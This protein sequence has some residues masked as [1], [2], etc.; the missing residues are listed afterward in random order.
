MIDI[1][2]TDN[3]SL[4]RNYDDQLAQPLITSNDNDNDNDNDKLNIDYKNSKNYL[5]FGHQ[6]RFQNYVI[7]SI[8]SLLP[9]K[10]KIKECSVLN[11]S[12]LCLDVLPITNSNQVKFQLSLVYNGDMGS[13]KAGKV[14]CENM[15][16]T[17]YSVPQEKFNDTFKISRN[18][19]TR[20]L[21]LFFVR[22]GFSEHNDKKTGKKNTSL[23]ESG[24][25]AS[26]YSGI[27]F[28]KMYPSIKIEAV[29][30]SDLIRTQE[31][32]GHFLS[33]LTDFNVNTPIIVLPCLHESVFA[34]GL[35]QSL[36]FLYD[37]DN[38]DKGYGF[39][40]LTDCNIKEDHIEGDTNKTNIPFQGD[41]YRCYY[42]TINNNNIPID[43][44]IYLNFYN[45]KMREPE[46]WYNSDREHCRNNHFLGMFFNYLNSG[47]M[48]M[49]I[50]KNRIKGDFYGGKK[51]RQ[52]KKQRVMKS[53]KVRRVKKHN[54][55]SKKVKRRSNKRKA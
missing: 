45:G 27:E 34:D 47:G 28:N 24:V 14:Y 23:L 6:Y 31:T 46:S 18:D 16:E 11:N 3:N 25:D 26:I 39:E 53:K 55:K 49:F 48:F 17:S 30:V 41:R 38:N 1:D 32:A 8:N 29:F 42:I 4:W 54:K 21:K 51:R 13:A 44:Q 2:D 22:H 37:N 15:M 10:K 33:Q 50:L 9:K 43:W 20:Q 36:G 5:F 52:T 12:I 19:N 7:D 40:N 35:K